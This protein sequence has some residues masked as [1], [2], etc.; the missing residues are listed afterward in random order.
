[1][2]IVDTN[3][4][5]PSANPI[6][7]PPGVSA[8]SAG[9]GITIT[10]TA[11]NPIISSASGSGAVQSVEGLVGAIDLIGSGLAITTS[12]QTITLTSAVSTLIAGSNCS[13]S[14]SP[15][16]TF[17]ITNTSTPASGLTITQADFPI[18]VAASPVTRIGADGGYV[19]ANLYGPI[20]DATKNSSV[21]FQIRM[22]GVG[23]KLQAPL[24]Q[25]VMRAGLFGPTGELIYY[26][27]QLV[28]N[29]DVNWGNSIFENGNE[30]VI[31]TIPIA[32]YQAGGL[33]LGWNIVFPYNAN[34][35]Y[36]FTNLQMKLTMYYLA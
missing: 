12:G 4:I 31:G 16:G 35:F 24:L 26:N 34:P 9:T 3:W 25:N 28:T 19:V 32:T 6:N 10:G 18:N 23:T 27:T 2:S 5:V 21:F 33:Y 17:T 11:Q 30:T 29:M 1:M 15:P 22:S 20:I 7:A 8:V 36:S 13:I 14:E